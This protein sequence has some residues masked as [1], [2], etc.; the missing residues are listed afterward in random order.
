[1]AKGADLG[2]EDEE[3]EVETGDEVVAG[4]GEGLP[5]DVEDVRAEEGPEEAEEEGED[6]VVA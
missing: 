1:V 6:F 4:A 5:N 3:G 2:A